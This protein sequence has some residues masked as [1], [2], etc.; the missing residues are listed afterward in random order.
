ME[1]T[2]GFFHACI[3]AELTSGTAGSRGYFVQ[4]AVSALHGRHFRHAM[5][6]DLLHKAL[7]FANVLYRLEPTGLDPADG[8]R[9]D[10]ITTVPWSNSRL[11][12]W[13]ATPLP[14]P[15]YPSQPNEVCA[16]ANQAE[17]NK[18]QKYS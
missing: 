5:L 9:P 6:N 18:I 13:D 4:V 2:K 8:N 15:I 17:Q 10:G 3:A 16:A 12:V 14:L 11:L 7:S 1:S